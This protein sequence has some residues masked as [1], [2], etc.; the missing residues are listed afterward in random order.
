MR[1]LTLVG[2]FVIV[3]AAAGL[4]GSASASS[5]LVVLRATT[6]DEL[7]TDIT[8]ANSSG[9]PTLIRVTP[10]HY[11][12]SRTFNSDWG[13]SALPVIRSP[14]EIIGE[15][16][17]GTILDAGQVP[18]RTFTVTRTGRLWLE[19]ITISG[20]IA[21]CNGDCTKDGGGAIVS[22]GNVSTYNTVITGAAAGPSL[23]GPAFTYG[24]AILIIGGYLDLKKTTLAGNSSEGNGGALAVLG[25]SV[26]LTS[27]LVQGNGALFMSEGEGGTG[28]GGGIYVGAGLLTI[29]DSTITGNASGTLEDFATAFGVGIYNAGGTVTIENSAV[30]ENTIPIPIP[31]VSA[32]P[33]GNAGAGG[34]IYNG[35]TM[36]IRDSTIAG[37]LVGTL[38]GGIF[39][40][41]KLTLQGVTIADN[42]VL[43]TNGE[44]FELG[45]YPPACQPDTN[46]QGCI[47][48]GSGI[49]NDPAG[50]VYIATSA[51]AANNGKYGPGVGA[52]CFGVLVSN[53]HNA[54]GT[55]F[56]CTLEP[57]AALKGQPTDDLVNINAQ[58]GVLQ[59]DGKP[60]N[61]HY[62]LQAD[63]PLIGT[64]GRVGPYCTSLDQ[65]GDPRA[66]GIC[67]IGAI[68]FEPPK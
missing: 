42:A 29:S 31:G 22:Q 62:P 11:T 32:N 38:G 6:V 4:Q 20:G 47:Q 54:L 25:G 44:V 24:G 65:I 14:V 16:P 37:N 53:G 2:L 36:T 40:S 28:N 10:G 50:T 39:N 17:S 8:S 35:A 3:M 26:A 23:Q 9:K 15:S 55:D 12:F 52:D 57:S 58:L 5:D 7:I 21:F 30:T 66:H 56:G 34:G 45:G 1:A 49:S 33:V 51:I 13:P 48:G 64:G 41:G 67:D 46:P 18:A 19:N 68:Q 60:G 59:D 27:C 43:G 63:S 61:A